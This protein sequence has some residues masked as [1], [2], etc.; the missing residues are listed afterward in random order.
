MFVSLLRRKS[1]RAIRFD[2]HTLQLEVIHDKTPNGSMIGQEFDDLF[3]SLGYL[4]IKQPCYNQT[5]H[6]HKYAE[7]IPRNSVYCTN[8]PYEKECKDRTYKPHNVG[9]YDEIKSLQPRRKQQ[10]LDHCS[11]LNPTFS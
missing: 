10:N 5:N 6:K 2:L 4:G 8:G 7:D 11:L 9:S 3:C 1:K